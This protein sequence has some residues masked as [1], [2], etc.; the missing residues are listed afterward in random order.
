MHHRKLS[1]EQTLLI[2]NFYDSIK[3]FSRVAVLDPC[4]QVLKSKTL[5]LLQK[6]FQTAADDSLEIKPPLSGSQNKSK[7]KRAK[8]KHPK[9]WF[10]E[11]CHEM[12]S[13]TRKVSNLKHHNP[14]NTLYQMKHRQV[15]RQYK[16][17]CL[18]KKNTFWILSNNINK[19][20]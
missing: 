11:E 15:M 3:E 19:A 20:A 14:N 8:K 16:K 10:D 9:K 17:L 7:G 1:T 4:S 2:L 18:K 13:T 5:Q 12:K 6:I